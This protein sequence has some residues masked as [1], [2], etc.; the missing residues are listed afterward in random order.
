VSGRPRVAASGTTGS[1]ARSLRALQFPAEDPV[2]IHDTP[3]G[4][5]IRAAWTDAS[6]QFTT[7]G[8]LAVAVIFWV[9]GLDEYAA[10]AT[11]ILN[12]LLCK[13]LSTPELLAWPH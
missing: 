2:R 7:D 5:T 8:I 4:Q 3:P 1:S 9:G 10:A 12:A 11:E 6:R 13:S